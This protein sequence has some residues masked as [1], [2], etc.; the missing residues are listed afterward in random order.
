MRFILIFAISAIIFACNTAKETP[1]NPEKE[2]EIVE[3]KVEELKKPEII[4]GKVRVSKEGEG[5]PVLIEAYRN[6][7][8]FILYPLNL[9]ERYKLDGMKI[10]F[11]YTPS[12]APLPANCQAD[13][14]GVL[15][16]TMPL[17]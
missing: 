7:E 6:G 12:K 11:T 4:I 15:E 3:E 1:I 16:N 14:V 2:V 9:I 10:K 8:M 17:Y 5:C 13:V